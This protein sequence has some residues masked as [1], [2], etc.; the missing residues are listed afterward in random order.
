MRT[1]PL[2][3]T[4]STNTSPSIPYSYTS[5]TFQTSLSQPGTFST[6]TLPEPKTP[7][8]WNMSDPTIEPRDTLSHVTIP[9]QQYTHQINFATHNI[10]GINE[11]LKYRL[12]IEFCH[13]QVL[14]IVS[15]TE[16]KI[17]E[18]SNHRL[19]L[20]NPYFCIYTANSDEAVSLKQQSSMETALA[21]RRTLQPYIHNIRTLPGT[22]IMID[23]FLPRSLKM[24]VISIYLPP[25][26]KRL[27]MKTQRVVA[28][29][30]RQSSNKNYSTV[31]MGDF[32]HDRW[33]HGTKKMDLFN[34]LNPMGI[35]SL[36]QYFDISSPTW[37]RNSLSSQIDDIYI[38]QDMIP[39]IT[40]PEIN[41]L[42]ST[43]NSNY[44]LIRASWITHQPMQYFRN[45]KRKRTIYLYKDMT[46]EAW[47]Q[48]ANG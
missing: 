18:A 41:D 24:R 42:Q 40:K 29:W 45:K 22:A 48:F 27:N 17:V 37:L 26:N 47:E 39:T 13:E 46:Q 30:A 32:N 4:Y 10:Q 8:P 3:K 19:F 11:P 31:L 25:G 38:S 21:I 2:Q 23:M 1:F 14:D 33:K 5:L 16:T 6:I 36:L 7:N 12:W 44:K 43:T 20:A 15:M 28:D 34:E 35:I 9:K